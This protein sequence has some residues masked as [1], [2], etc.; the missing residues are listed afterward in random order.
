MTKTDYLENA[1]LNHTLRNVPYTPPTTIYLA[2][3][4]SPTTDA[5]GGTEV[6]G[7]G[8]ARQAVTFGAPSGGA[9]A[10]TNIVTFPVASPAGWGTVTHAAVFDSL[11]GGNMLR[12]GALTAAKTINA[13]DA[14]TFQ[15]GQVVF[16]ED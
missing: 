10:N 15:V 4:T 9:V 1:V 3:F 16:S 2:A 5:G 14:L 7:N 8:Y 6:A 11:T 12:H 13:G